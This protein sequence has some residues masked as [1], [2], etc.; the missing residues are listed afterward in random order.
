MRMRMRM[1]MIMSDTL[2]Q[3]QSDS[4][5]N[6]SIPSK[7]ILKFGLKLFISGVCFLQLYRNGQNGLKTFTRYQYFENTFL[8]CLINHTKLSWRNLFCHNLPNFL[9]GKLQICF[10]PSI[11]S[12]WPQSIVLAARDSISV[13]IDVQLIPVSNEY[14]KKFNAVRGLHKKVQFQCLQICLWSVGLLKEGWQIS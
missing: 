10:L 6:S 7:Y 1:R 2:Q 8:Q 11:I 13:Q 3:L 5:P 14:W 9:L 4:D 12:K